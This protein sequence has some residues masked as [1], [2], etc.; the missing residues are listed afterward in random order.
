MADH[1]YARSDSRMP[2]NLQPCEHSTVHGRTCQDTVPAATSNSLH[3]SHTAPT[4]HTATHHPTSHTASG[5]TQVTLKNSS[6]SRP[7][8]LLREDTE[9]GDKGLLS[10]IWRRLAMRW[11][12]PWVFSTC[13]LYTV[14]LAEFDRCHLETGCHQRLDMYMSLHR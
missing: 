11:C 14:R 9:T 2:T 3:G 12:G 7:L 4:S 13:L 1:L 10:T 6:S 5:L 8:V